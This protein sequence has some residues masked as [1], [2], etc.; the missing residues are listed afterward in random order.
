MSSYIFEAGDEKIHQQ[1]QIG[2]I[3]IHF[4]LKKLNILWNI[5][6]Y[7]SFVCGILSFHEYKCSNLIFTHTWMKKKNKKSNKNWKKF[8]FTAVPQFSQ[9]THV[10]VIHYFLEH[11]LSTAVRESLQGEVRMSTIKKKREQLLQ[12]QTCGFQSRSA[13]IRKNT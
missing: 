3:C 2:S 10:H 5:K 1:T 4:N 12:N 8:T 6:L 13:H 11:Y 9:N 7:K